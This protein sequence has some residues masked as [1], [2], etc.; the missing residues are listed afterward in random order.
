MLIIVQ[1]IERFSNKE[2]IFSINIVFE[3]NKAKISIIFK[4]QNTINILRFFVIF[5]DNRFTKFLTLS[6]KRIDSNIINKNS[7]KDKINFYRY[8]KLELDN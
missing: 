6:K 5:N 4:V 1:K 7:I 3:Q 8:K 2:I